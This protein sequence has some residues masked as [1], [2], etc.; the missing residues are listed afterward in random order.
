MALFQ[1]QQSHIYRY[2]VNNCRHRHYYLTLFTARG[3]S[4]GYV[5]TNPDLPTLTR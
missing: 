5:L 1:V 4:Y 3:Y 2:F